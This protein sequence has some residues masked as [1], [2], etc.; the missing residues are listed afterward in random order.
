MTATLSKQERLNA[1]LSKVVIA[2]WHV[3]P[4]FFAAV[5]FGLTLRLAPELASAVLAVLPAGA[6]PAL[7]LVRGDALRLGGQEAAARRAWAE[8]AATVDDVWPQRPA[9]EDGAQETKE[10]S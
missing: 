5:R 1:I 2:T 6:D 9:P 10:N 7:D 4:I 8:A 3:P